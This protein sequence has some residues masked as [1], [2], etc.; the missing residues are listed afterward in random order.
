MNTYYC[1]NCKNS[2]SLEELYYNTDIGKP[3]LHYSNNQQEHL[4]SIKCPHCEL[5]VLGCVQLNYTKSDILNVIDTEFKFTKKDHPDQC[6]KCLDM[7]FVSPDIDSEFCYPVNR[8]KTLF[9]VTC[10]SGG[11][12]GC[13]L[14]V[15]FKKT[16]KSVFDTAK[17]IWNNLD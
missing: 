15:Q 4:L 10:N 5:I 8:E 12:I 2:S 17:E 3:F 6:P 9:K 14:L 7:A 11:G 16:D 1:P 13:G